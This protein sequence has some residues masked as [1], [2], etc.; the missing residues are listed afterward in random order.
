MSANLL[1]GLLGTGKLLIERIWP[2]PVRRSEEMLKLEALHQKGDLA[3]LDAEVKILQGQAQINLV[4]AQSKSLFIAGWRPFIGWVGGGA[5]A[6]QFI[7][8]PLLIWVWVLLEMPHAP[9]PAMDM[10]PL[11]PMITAMLGIGAMR[12]YDK[13][14]GT[15]TDNL[16]GRMK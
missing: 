10:G 6:Y 2:D 4:E 9:P 12:S 1:A 13:K 7:L 15:Q 14:C 8:H 11:F 5:L 3:A 16:S